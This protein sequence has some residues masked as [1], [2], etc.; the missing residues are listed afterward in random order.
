M[1]SPEPSLWLLVD[2]IPLAAGEP[3]MDGPT[4]TRIVSRALHLLGAIILGG[5]VFYIRSV[6]SDAGPEACFAGRR[7][8]W[9]R[10]IAV[11]STVLIATGLFNY[12]MYV[13]DAKA[14]GADALPQTYHMLFGIKFLLALGLMGVASIVAGKTAAAERAR[15][16]M[17]RWL[18][19]AWTLVMAIVV[20][21][22][23]MRFFH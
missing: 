23:M 17:P 2:L 22:A 16:N 3:T 12:I 10:W 9:S 18:N 6:L 8:V 21:G 15:A 20:V 7:Q 19:V 4:I 13:R 11:A 5:G 1:H 14:P